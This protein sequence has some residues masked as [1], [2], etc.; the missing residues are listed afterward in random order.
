MNE[1]S[2]RPAARWRWLLFTLIIGGYPLLATLNSVVA[3]GAK[4]EVARLP[5]APGL[6]FFATLLE[7]GI[8]GALWALGWVWTKPDREQLWVRTVGW[9]KTWGLGALY[10]LG[11]RVAIVVAVSIGA[12]GAAIAGFSPA[13]IQQFFQENNPN[14]ESVV[15]AK[16]VL[17]DPLY[18][19]LLTTWVS[20][21]VAGLREELWRA[22]TLRGL[23]ELSPSGWSDSLRNSLAVGF[24]S[25]IFALGHLPQ[26]WLACV[27]IFVV[28]NCLGAI[29]LVH[30]SIW[31]AVVA[32]GFFNALSFV[33]AGF[34]DR[35]PQTPALW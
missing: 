16:K 25:L 13:E 24:S 35:L 30:R 15:N 23:F 33:A 17:A 7:L 4:R 2:H 21:V 5:D 10:S 3:I 1:I 11:L 8:F 19:L 27:L 26:G 32:H 29:V 22:A 14:I 9:R 20:F 34:S 12:L 28:G 31:P 18:A 6:L